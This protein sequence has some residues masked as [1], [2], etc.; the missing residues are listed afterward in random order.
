MFEAQKHTH[1]KMHI[2]QKYDFGSQIF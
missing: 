2:F 1:I